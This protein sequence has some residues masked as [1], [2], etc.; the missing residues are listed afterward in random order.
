VDF[1][2]SQCAKDDCIV[3]ELRGE[4]DVTTVPM[5]RP[6]L[7]A[8]LDG[9][10]QHIILDLAELTFIDSSAL[11]AIVIADRRARQL[12]VT[13][14][15]AAA[16]RIVARVIGITGLDRHFPVYPTVADAA[17]GVQSG[18]SATRREPI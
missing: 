16:Q 4:L 17:A 8:L 6:A 2:L 15:L 18:L 10:A 11:T 7:H 12:G 1:E 13:I 5:L 14:A 9:K 3:V